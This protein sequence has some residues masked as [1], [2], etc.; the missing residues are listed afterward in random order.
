[1]RDTP[2]LPTPLKKY[3]KLVHA[4]LLQTTLPVD[5][6]V[7]SWHIGRFHHFQCFEKLSIKRT[8]T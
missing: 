6:N 8:E 7:S 4:I 1:M 2:T 3:Y 5:S